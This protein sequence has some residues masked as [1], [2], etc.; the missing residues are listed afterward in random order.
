M[1]APIGSKWNHPIFRYLTVGKDTV[2]EDGNQ[3][4]VEELQ[5]LGYEPEKA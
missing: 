5:A 4:T 3:I 2:G 1:P